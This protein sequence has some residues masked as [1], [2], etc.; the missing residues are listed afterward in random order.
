MSAPGRSSVPEPVA[1]DHKAIEDLL[2]ALSKG[3]RAI[4]LYLPNNPMYEQACNNVATAFE[5]V[6]QVT[7]EIDLTVSDSEFQWEDEAVYK[8]PNKGDSLASMLYEYGV[9]SITLSP[10]VEETEAIHFL[11]V[12]N[13]SADAPAGG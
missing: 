11:E 8:E 1:A 3:M 6:W 5:A 2:Q 10:G 13:R 12:L 9:R 4:Q 7:D